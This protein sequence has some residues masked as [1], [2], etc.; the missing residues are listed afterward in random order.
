M[1]FSDAVN[2][3][4]AAVEAKRARDEDTP[5]A[6]TATS[7]QP[8]GRVDDV[9]EEEEMR[10]LGSFDLGDHGNS[11]AR[12]AGARNVDLFD[13]VGMLGNLWRRVQLR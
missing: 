1:T 9:D 11:V 6:H 4:K 13:A 2:K 8:R 5:G 12:E 3:I 7:F 10:M